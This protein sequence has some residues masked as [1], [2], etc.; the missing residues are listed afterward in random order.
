MSHDYFSETWKYLGPTQK[1][2][3]KILNIM[4]DGKGIIPY[5]KIVHFN[6]FS[7]TPED[8]IFFEKCEFCSD[9]KQKSVNDEDYES[10][11][12]LYTTSKMRNLGDK[13]DLCNTQD[14]IL[15]CEII[16]NRFQLKH[17]RYGFNPR[18]C[19][20]ASSLS[21]SIERDLAKVLVALPTT[22]KIID[23][24]EQTLTGGF[25]CVNIRLAF[26]TEILLRN[27]PAKVDDVLSKDLNYKVCYRLKLDGDENYVTRRVISKMLKLD[28]N[29]Q[30]GYA[31]TK[32]LP[33][34]CIK[35][36]PQPTWKILDIL[37]Q[38]V[39]LDDP[40]GHLFVVDIN[41]NYEKAN[42]R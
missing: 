8:G 13:N 21:G 1:E 20:S 6:S 40:V 38:K 10:S 28:E 26:D 5:E 30:C 39:V 32:P 2:K 11:I 33:T 37:L 7:L 23:I 42:R 27:H 31:M 17:D 41:F 4:A 12:Y 25:S 22:T 24:F 29:I 36:E 3:E 34:G 35:K 14:V 9:L 18:K 16:E 15:L 19:N